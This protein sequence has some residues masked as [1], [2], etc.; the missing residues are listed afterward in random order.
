MAFRVFIANIIH[1]AFRQRT[2]R[3]LK[4]RVPLISPLFAI[5]HINCL[6]MKWS[7]EDIVKSNQIKFGSNKLS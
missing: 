3:Y 5:K 4:R 1:Y 6:P 7:E 2:T